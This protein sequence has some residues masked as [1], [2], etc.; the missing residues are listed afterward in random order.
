M[1][2]STGRRP[3]WRRKPASEVSTFKQAENPG[4][5]CNGAYQ[6]SVS[7]FMPIGPY[8]VRDRLPSRAASLG[9]RRTAV[10][11]TA[12]HVGRVLLNGATANANAATI[13]GHMDPFALVRLS[14]GRIVRRRELLG[15]EDIWARFGTE[16]SEVQILSPRPLLL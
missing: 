3:L 13:K 15:N 6:P 10:R 7:S 14:L 12:A 16:G 4:E 9:D 8:A 2:T 11:Y 5:E 1:A